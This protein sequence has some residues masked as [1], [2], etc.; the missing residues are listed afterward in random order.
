MLAIVEGIFDNAMLT[1]TVIL[2]SKA[3]DR[4]G[5][6]PAFEELQ[7]VDAKNLARQYA[8]KKGMP[9]PRIS[10]LRA[11]VYA[12]NSEG[13]S[14]DQVFDDDKKPLPGT[15]PRMKTAGYRIDIQLTAPPI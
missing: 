8:V 11:G 5:F 3:S 2:E 7:S 10:S 14:L 4:S 15:H 9:D 6:G 12:V 13:L 1:G